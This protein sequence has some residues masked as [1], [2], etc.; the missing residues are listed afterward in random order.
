MYNF[1]SYSSGSGSAGERRA[2]D[3]GREG[4]GWDGSEG[5]GSAE[6][7]GESRRAGFLHH[8]QPTGQSRSSSQSASSA[9][10]LSSAVLSQEVMMQMNLLELILKLQQ[11]ETVS[12]S[13]PWGRE[14]TGHE[15]SFSGS[16][17]N[18]RGWA[19]LTAAGRW[20]FKSIDYS[21]F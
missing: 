17:W 18:N 19:A 4:R 16:T 14:R 21:L 1:D 11:K 20:T 8:H 10:L 9:F 15:S 7:A 13:L 3:D 6:H 12:G 2:E 5:S